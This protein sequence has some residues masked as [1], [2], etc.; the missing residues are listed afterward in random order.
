MYNQEKELVS[1]IIPVYNVEKYIEKCLRSVMNQTYTNIEIIVVNDKTPDHSMEIVRR[2]ADEDNRIVILEHEV[3]SKQG[4]ARNTGL[5]ASKGEYIIFLDSD[6][7]LT[8]DAV[9]IL[10]NAIKKDNFDMVISRM[11]WS[12]HGKIEPV[13][14]IEAKLCAYELFSKQNLREMENTYMYVGQVCNRIHSRKLLM[15]N[16]IFF[17]EGI[18]WEDVPFSIEC[19]LCAQKISYIREYTYLRIEREDAENLSTT[20]DYSMK[21]YL[22]REEIEKAVYNI[23]QK[24][25]TEKAI[26]LKDAKYI[27]DLVYNTTKNILAYHNESIDAWIES[28]FEQYSVGHNEL[29]EKIG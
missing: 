9:E 11:G 16:N 13:A 6:D 2:L 8:L 23:V 20:Q 26:S 3:N 1:V 17:P 18:F 24:H 19:W 27:L 5:K 7:V 14:Y 10:Y 12:H 29:L 22:D 4:A 25:Y 28:W 15:D 21:K